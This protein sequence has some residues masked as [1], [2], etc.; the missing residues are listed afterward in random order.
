MFKALIG[1]LIES[2]AQTLVNTVNCV[3]I[4]GKGIALEFKK[5]YPE[6]F[7]DYKA[8]CDAKTVREKYKKVLQV[9]HE[10]V[11]KTVDL[12]SRI[13]STDQAEEV[14]TVLFTANRLKRKAKDSAL[15]EQKVYDA[16]LEWK[17]HWNTPEKQATIASAI[18]NLV[19]LDW[20]KVEFS[21]SLP[22]EQA[23][24]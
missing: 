10:A 20:M 1:D 5:R 13:Q 12:F 21:E 9:N 14:T 16:I 24:S 15:T 8:R 23:I 22:V 17:K 3:G 18:R 2:Q 19:M 7:E 6:M 4:R 11:Q